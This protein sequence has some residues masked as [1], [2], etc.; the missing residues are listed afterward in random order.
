VCLA[1]L[2]HGRVKQACVLGCLPR[3]AVLGCKQLVMLLTHS[4]YCCC[5]W[6]MLSLRPQLLHLAC[7]VLG[8]GSFTHPPT[9]SLPHNLINTHAPAELRIYQPTH[10]VSLPV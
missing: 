2:G 1:F 8:M 5:Q 9:L 3:W 10:L 4:T 6:H 7:A